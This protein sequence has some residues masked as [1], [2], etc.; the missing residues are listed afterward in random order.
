MAGPHLIRLY[1][2]GSGML[3]TLALRLV[4]GICEEKLAGRYDLEVVDV[5]QQ[6]SRAQRDGI[7]AAPT[8]VKESPAP[9]RRL[10]G[11]LTRDLVLL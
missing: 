1:I 11:R 10:V 2:E 8:L 4:K 6:F 3:S 9:S 7:V 5:H